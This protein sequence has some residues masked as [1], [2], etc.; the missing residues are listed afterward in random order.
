MTALRKRYP[1]RKQFFSLI[2][3]RAGVLCTLPEAGGGWDSETGDG[4][5][6][7]CLDRHWIWI[8]QIRRGQWSGP[9]LRRLDP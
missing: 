3:Q 9:W 5:A 8:R 7:R 4:E 6:W 2:S 1:V